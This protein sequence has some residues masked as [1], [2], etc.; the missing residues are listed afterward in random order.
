MRPPASPTD[1][2]RLC[3]LIRPRLVK[4]A[5]T[6]GLSRFDAE[7]PVNQTLEKVHE[8]WEEKYQPLSEDKREAY[9]MEQLAT[10]V[11]HHRRREG[12][13]NKERGRPSAFPRAILFNRDDYSSVNWDHVTSPRDD[14]HR[15]DI[16]AA[17]RLLSERQR[18]IVQLHIF[19]GLPQAEVAR[20]LG[21]S[22]GTIN[23]QMSNIRKKLLPWAIAYRNPAA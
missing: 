17:V 23:K 15:P 7:D 22:S 21:L 2:D 8:T 5:R 6:L 12:R 9:C 4:R 11:R 18:E 13:I 19:E 20:R 1:L 3:E 10:E 14:W 16:I